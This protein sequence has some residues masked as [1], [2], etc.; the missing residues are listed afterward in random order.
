MQTL[1]PA[2][3]SIL[4]GLAFDSI[5]GLDLVG[6]KRNTL[7]FWCDVI[8]DIWDWTCDWV[9]NQ[10]TSGFEL[11]EAL[12]APSLSSSFVCVFNPKLQLLQE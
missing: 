10:I 2:Q 5:D 1:N 3:L 7:N 6:K 11:K 8:V 9:L 12:D 4:H